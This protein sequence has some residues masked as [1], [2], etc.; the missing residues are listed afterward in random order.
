MVDTSPSVRPDCRS[1]S[2]LVGH[3]VPEH[4]SLTEEALDIAIAPVTLP[5]MSPPAA[6][7]KPMYTRGP[8]PDCEPVAAAGVAGAGA[9]SE[10]AG[11]EVLTGGEAGAGPE[12]TSF[13]SISRDS[14]SARVTVVAAVPPV[15]ERAE[16]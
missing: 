12:K 6:T 13:S 7:P 16:I 2:T 4:A 5:T 10:E 3:V 14:A 9:G 15:V 8:S 1:L 11:A